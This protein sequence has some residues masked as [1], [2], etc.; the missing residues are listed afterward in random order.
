MAYGDVA[1][2]DISRNLLLIMSNRQQVIQNNKVTCLSYGKYS[3]DCGPGSIY[4]INR[5]NDL[6]E[7]LS[8][9]FRESILG[10]RLLRNKL[11]FL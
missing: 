1:V 4:I 3:E 6:W 11:F 7:I 2:I 10:T 8:K 5:F 9:L